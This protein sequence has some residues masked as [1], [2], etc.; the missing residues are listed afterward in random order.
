MKVEPERGD[1]IH[2]DIKFLN[3]YSLTIYRSLL[4][5]IPIDQDS[6]AQKHFKILRVEVPSVRF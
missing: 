2:R 6:P 3:V 1:D 5:P 4:G